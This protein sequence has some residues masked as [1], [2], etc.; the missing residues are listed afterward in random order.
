MKSKSWTPPL[1]P[2]AA[3]KKEVFARAASVTEF[4]HQ[5]GEYP[6]LRS[7]SLPIQVSKIS[8]APV[9]Q[10]IDYLEEC[11]KKYRK[12]TG[13]GRA[14]CAVQVG[15]PERFAAV[16]TP[17]MEVLTIVNP[18]IT[19][20]SETKF[21]YPEICMSANPIVVPV[22][23]PGW[24]EFTYYDRTGAQQTWT[25]KDDTKPGRLMNCVF[26]HEIDHMEGIVNVDRVE[27][28]KL[29]ILDSD[30][31]FYDTADFEEV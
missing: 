28:P 12:L 21:R 22:V 15:I 13:Y 27:S 14:I 25:T 10:K 6:P 18:K 3:Y 19:K 7:S 9:Q 24:I 23:R 4:V 11:L 29:L 26:Q 30:P 17:E 1:A 8:S 31:K 16:F 5:I 2:F 20:T